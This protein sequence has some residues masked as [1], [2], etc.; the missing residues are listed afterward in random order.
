MSFW[1]LP[2]IGDVVGMIGDSLNARRRRRQTR[3]EAEIKAHE[4]QLEQDISWEAL[5]ARNA[6]SSWK[7]EYLT[8]VLTLPLIASFIPP[9]VP[10]VE[11][12]FKALEQMPVWYR[13][14]LGVVIAAAFGVKSFVSL[15]GIKK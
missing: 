4:K 13:A 12:G 6:A 8:I 15:M 2:I 11:A 1:K 10:Y 7:D 3:L 5:Q 14:S 9:L